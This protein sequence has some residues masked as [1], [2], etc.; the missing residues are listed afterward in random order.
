QVT[1]HPFRE[2]FKGISAGVELSESHCLIKSF[3][4][5]LGDS[6]WSL[7]GEIK[8]LLK[9]QT[10]LDLMMDGSS[11]SM[12]RVRDFLPFVK[13]PA[14]GK[15]NAHLTIQ[16]PADDPLL[17]L[18]LESSDAGVGGLPLGP[19]TVSLTFKHF[20]LT[21][22]DLKAGLLSGALAGS[23]KVLFD[24]GPHGM[25]AAETD[26]H[27]SEK[28]GRLGDLKAFLPSLDASGAVNA[29]LILRGASGPLRM[30]ASWE[31]PGPFKLSGQTLGR[32]AGSLA[33]D[34]RA[35]TV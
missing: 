6:A 22:L 21:L 17:A 14:T 25:R 20:L 8:G 23:G 11:V 9:G 7:S 16:G 33:L 1:V 2:D 26:I 13:S 3:S 12:E 32:F 18:T 27:I 30:Q 34:G 4:A 35:F 19:L 24:Q 15:S 10:Q 31:V 5:S 28:N 29:D